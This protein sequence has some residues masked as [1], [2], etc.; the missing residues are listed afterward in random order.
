MS[1][2]T[3]DFIE[4]DYVATDK[5]TNTIFDLTTEAEARKHNLYNEK[6]QY[7]PVK[8]CLGEGHLIPGLDSFLLGK[9]P[10]KEYVIEILPEQ[11]FGKKDP[12]LMKIVPAKIF[13]KEN[14]R[15]FP[16]LHVNIDNFRGVIRTVSGGRIIVDFNHP[17]SGHT[18]QYKIKINKLINEPREKIETLLS[19]F[20]KDPK[21][22]LQEDKLQINSKIPKQMQ[23]QLEE[24][25]KTLIPEVKEVIFK[26]PD[27]K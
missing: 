2:K 15:P 10:K 14:I 27:K 18:L 12:K 7:H 20:T 19:F 4:V 11:G 21:I 9:E 5:E 22:E 26:A 16:G 6:A 25:I 13:K 17:L 1:L 3:G 8:I 23:E 24:K